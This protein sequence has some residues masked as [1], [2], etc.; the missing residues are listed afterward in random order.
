MARTLKSRLRDLTPQFLDGLWT[1][2]E[3]SPL[4]ERLLRGTFWS[5]LGT[6][7][8]RALGLA[9]AILAARILGKAVYGELGIIQSTVGMLGTF[10]GFGMGTTATK[11][12]AELRVNDPMKA[13]RIIAMSSVV[14]W[15]VSLALLVILYVVAPWLCLHTLAAPQLTGYVRVSGL[16]LVVSGVNGAQLGVLSGF[17]AFKSI[18]RVSS[19]TGLLNFPLIVGGAF[20][21]G[22]A[23]VI[24]GMAVAQ[25]MG[26]FLNMRALRREAN[27][28]GIPISFSSC[29]SEIPV[30]WRFSAPAVLG[31]AMISLVNWIAATM[32]VRRPSGYSE[33]GAFNAANQ[34]FNALMWLPY[35]VSGVTL[36]VL[37]ERLGAGDKA[38]TV[39]LLKMT[40]TTNAVF[41]LPVMAM[42]CLLSRYIMMSY[43]KGFSSAWPTLI[44]VLITAAMLSLEL[45]VGE[46]IAAAGHMWL[47]LFSNIGWGIIFL[48][49]ASFLLKWGSLGLASSRLL[50]YTAHTIFMGA[51]LAVFIL[52]SRKNTSVADPADVPALTRASED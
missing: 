35:I 41:V 40:F 29:M 50:A 12:V 5:L 33:M 25:A 11:Y 48:G 27:R 22:L 26:C 39:K 14:S 2:L 36:P 34:W 32:L 7:A 18:A 3:S 4:G 16:L 42:G 17:E 21:F 49:S 23:G 1:R 31:S 15:G 9:A 24:W 10:A 6:F 45:I 43:G 47:G 38:N 19:L 13:G 52:A 44:V 37:S 28:C 20:F 8:A 30:V 46:L 51:Y